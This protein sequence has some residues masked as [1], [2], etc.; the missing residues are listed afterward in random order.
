M[1]MR[2]PLVIDAA[3][4][5]LWAIEEPALQLMIEIASREHQVTPE[6][7]EAYRAQE[8]P[9]AERAT[10]RNGVAII[11]ASGPMFKRAN[12]MTQ[13]CGATS[14][15]LMRRDLQAAV[16]NYGVNAILLNLDTPG[17]EAAGVAELAQAVHDV[18]GTKPIVTYAGDLAASAGYWLASASDAIIIGKTAAVGSI[19]VRMAITDTSERDEAR[20]VKTYE[21]VSSQSPNKKVDLSTKQGRN[22]VQER[23][24]AMAA[25]FVETV[26]QYRGVSVDTVLNQF[27]KGGVLIGQAAVDAGMADGIGTFES[28]LASLARGEK[29]ARKGANPAASGPSNERT[30]MTVETG[31]PTAETQPEATTLIHNAVSHTVAPTAAA[32]TTAAAPAHEVSIAAA[33][34]TGERK[35]VMDI[36]ALTLP[37]YEEA[38]AK[39]IEAGSSAHEF[40]AMIV[41]S[42][43]AKRTARASAI[44]SD[45]AANAAIKPAGTGGQQATGHEAAA[46]SILNAMKIATGK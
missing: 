27:G 28:V 24:D 2:N 19:G 44:Q 13:L 16:D 32:T 18:R 45:T 4:G 38:A 6:A 31:A 42:E 21:F 41:S 29:P 40:S 11:S 5:A 3:I 8:L 39:A 43:K 26:A 14:Y 23:V 35:R 1:T 36:M 17:G 22:Q 15:E 33:A 37:G 30:I 46:T 9:R 34:T 12:L 7:L 25:V 10:I 20:G